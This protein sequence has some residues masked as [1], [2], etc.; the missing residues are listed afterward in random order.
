[1]DGIKKEYQVQ[2]MSNW[3]IFIFVLAVPLSLLVFVGIGVAVDGSVFSFIIG[4]VAVV[5]FMI[6]LY[7]YLQQKILVTVEGEFIRVNYLRSPFFESTFD[8]DI[9]PSDIES[10][11]FDNFNGVRFIL[12]LKD[13]RRFKAV[14]GS[15]GK[16][17]AIEQMAEHIIALINSGHYSFANTPPKR[18]STYA[19][20]TK[21]LVLA[22]VVTVAMIVMGV[23]M[24]FFPQNHSSVDTVRGIGVMCTCLAF[25]LHPN[26]ARFTPSI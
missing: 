25:V 12:Y 11:K 3:S 8:L 24:I 26:S 7:Q 19:E 17:S 23:A 10:Y 14:V 13:G 1:M 15:I 6:F 18:R 2:N 22:I 20:G 9:S 4:I 5:V 16:T 21:G